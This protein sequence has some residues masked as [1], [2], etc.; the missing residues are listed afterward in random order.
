MKAL[1]S[2]RWESNNEKLSYQDDRRVTM[3][4]LISGRW[5]GN[6][7]KLSYQ[8]DGRVIMKSC[9]IRVMRVG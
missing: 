7:E 5:E 4:G 9:R 2:G 8:D 6:N 3:R 1:I